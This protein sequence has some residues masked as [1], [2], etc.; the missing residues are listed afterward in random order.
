[1][2]ATTS[3]STPALGKM[4]PRRMVGIAYF[5]FA[6]AGGMFLSHVVAAVLH[7][8]RWNDPSVLGL[9]ELTLSALVG[10]ALSVGAVVYGWLSSTVRAA[11]LDVA[12]ELKRVTWPSIAETRVSTVAVIIASVVSAGVLF[13]FDLVSS[14]VMT[15]WVPAALGW[16]AKI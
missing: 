10:F 11:A 2:D 6:L 15:V 14:K 8:L 13:S 12:T 4:E 3:T 1:M 7:G 9:E 16:V 5:A